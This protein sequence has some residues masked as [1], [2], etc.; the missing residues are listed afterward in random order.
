VQYGPLKMTDTATR[1]AWSA[2][3]RSRMRPGFFDGAPA[4]IAFVDGFLV[5]DETGEDALLDH[6]PENRATIAAPVKW[7]GR[8]SG[9]LWDAFLERLWAGQPDADARKTIV[10]EFAGLALLGLIP[11]YERCLILH[12]SKAGNGK[13]TL[14][15]I[16]SALFH[17]SNRSAIPPQQFAIDT[18]LASMANSRWNCVNELPRKSILDSERFNAVISGN[19]I[20]VKP[21]YRDPFMLSPRAAHVFA[22]NELPG[23]I[24]DNEGFWRRVVVVEFPN[25]FREGQP[26]FDAK[27][28]DKIIERELAAVYHACIGAACQAVR[29]GKLTI[30]QSAGEAVEEWR[31]ETDT[32]RQWLHERCSEVAGSQKS[33]ASEVWRDYQQWGRE[34]GLKNPLSQRSFWK[35]LHGLEL[36]HKG[37]GGA[38]EFRVALRAP[39]AQAPLWGQSRSHYVT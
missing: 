33:S 8:S 13:S 7:A 37:T 3:K 30:P 35:R 22:C 18:Y 19:P 20:Q 2:A 17:E 31:A 25:V 5:V 26:G 36:G 15:R 23:T 11:R 14:L 4:G 29:R 38:R 32:V 28:A 10:L 16:L 27:L 12:G 34:A 6:S 39:L 21:L 24:P 9:G 1:G